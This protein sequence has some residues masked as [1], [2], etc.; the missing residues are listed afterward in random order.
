MNISFWYFIFIYVYFNSDCYFYRTEWFRFLIFNT[1]KISYLFV[2][3][4]LIISVIFFFKLWY[5]KSMKEWKLICHSTLILFAVLWL[6]HLSVMFFTFMWY[7]YTLFNKNSIIP[8][9]FYI[10]IE[11]IYH[12]KFFYWVY[13][14][15]FHWIDTNFIISLLSSVMT[16]HIMSSPWR[17]AR[18]LSPSCI[19]CPR[20]TCWLVAR[21]KKRI[22]NL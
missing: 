16:F 12:L 5:R 2:S 19:H 18:L 17:F 22:F 20:A 15:H 7:V 13:L 8:K 3:L 4:C 9:L 11:Y 14:Q 1:F 10:I 6:L 21:E